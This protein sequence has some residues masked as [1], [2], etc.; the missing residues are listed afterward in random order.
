MRSILLSEGVPEEAIVMET[1]AATTEENMIYGGLQMYRR[2]FFH[3]GKG[4]II[5]TSYRHM[6]RSLALA[7]TFLPH[8]A[9]I[10]AYPSETQGEGAEL[11]KLYNHEIRVMKCLVDNGIIEDLEIDYCL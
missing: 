4:V 11:L 10:S 3:S 7:R 2:T 5:V 8:M 1:E 6:K 9:E